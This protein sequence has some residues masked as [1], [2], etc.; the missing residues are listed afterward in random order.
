MSNFRAGAILSL[1]FVPVI[2]TACSGSS[3][4][5]NKTRPT[6]AANSSALNANTAKT[7]VEELGLLVRVS[8]E[9]EDVVWKENSNK[10][11]LIAVFRF[12][13]ADAEKVVAEATQFG[14]SQPNTI[15]PETWFP[16]ELIAQSEMSGD[17]ALKGLAYPANGFLQESYSS[18]KLTRIEGTDYFVLEATAK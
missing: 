13:P 2:F 11:S 16:S 8:Y 3:N 12:S 17:N 9:V 5:D 1:F 18:G 10:K 14:Q 15:S 6:I 4:S 7:N